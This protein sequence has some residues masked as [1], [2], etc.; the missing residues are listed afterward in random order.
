MHFLIPG[1]DDNKIHRDNFLNFLGFL[2]V[3]LLTFYEFA[4]IEVLLF[5]LP[6]NKKTSTS[7]KS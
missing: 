3:P 4:K 6:K 5:F 2:E 7:A 1:W